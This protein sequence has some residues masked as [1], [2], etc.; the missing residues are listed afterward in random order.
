MWGR[1]A[2]AKNLKCDDGDSCVT[3]PTRNGNSNNGAVNQGRRNNDRT[4]KLT[5]KVGG[6]FRM[7]L[8]CVCGGMIV[9]SRFTLLQ[10]YGNDLALIKRHHQFF[11]T[12]GCI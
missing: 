12:Y 6:V 4:F 7:L 10:R 2:L 1:V 3:A 11:L 9:Q 8:E 5:L